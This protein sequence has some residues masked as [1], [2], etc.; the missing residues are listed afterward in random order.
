MTRPSRC[1]WAVAVL[2]VFLLLPAETFAQ[3]EAAQP[4]VPAEGIVHTVVAGDTLWDLSAKYL[5]S[6]WKWPQIWEQNR[7]LTNPHFIYPG[8]KIVIVPPA[9]REVEL[10]VK[11]PPPEPP[12]PPSAAAEP[13]KAATASAESPKPAVALPL[14][15]PPVE[16]YL[17]IKPEDFVRAGEFTREAPRGIG[18]IRG[19]EEPKVGF[20]QGD[21]VYL[22]LDKEIP[23]GQLLGVYRVRGP[24]DVCGDRSYS[25]YVNY[26][27]GVLQV[28]EKRNGQVTATV[29]QSFEDLTRADMVSETIPGYVPV[30]IVPGAEGLSANVITGRMDNEELATGNFVYLDRGSAAGVA[31]GNVFRVLVPTGNATG[32][33][34]GG[35]GTGVLTDVARLVVVRVSPEFASAYVIDSTES[36]NAGSLTERGIADR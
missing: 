26:L 9:P 8:I 13:A 15:E 29:R 12:A 35:V 2:G 27:I 1:F 28:G 7:F 24:I 10:M 32:T 34:G 16:R 17:Q 36:F 31:V 3:Q 23:A 33:G 19:G 21:R 25:G 14:P 20:A 22:A 18:T 4:A 5:G 11:S 30:K 6:P